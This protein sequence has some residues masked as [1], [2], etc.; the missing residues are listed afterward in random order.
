[1]E[2]AAMKKIVP[3]ITLALGLWLL[4]LLLTVLHAQK[5][6]ADLLN[7]ESEASQTRQ[8]PQSKFKVGHRRVGHTIRRVTVPGS[9]QGELRVVEVH[10]WYPA[11]NERF[12]RAPKT[13]Y[14]SALYGRPLEWDPLIPAKWDPLSWSVEAEIA[15][16]DAPIDSN[17]QS[18]PVLVFSHGNTN[19]PFDYA[20]TLEQIAGEGFVVAAPSHT[21]NTQDDV[22]VDF[23]NEE[24]RLAGAAK[25]LFLCND[26]LPG[27]CFRNVVLCND[28]LPGPCFKERLP[29]VS[30]IT[31][32]MRDRV[33]DVTAVLDSL[34]G[35]HGWLG[36]RADVNR[37]G[38][39]G[40]SRGSVTA[41]AAAGGSTIWECGLSLCPPT[42][43][44]GPEPRVK[45]VMGLAI[46]VP[47]TTLA[48]NLANIT[49]PSLLVAGTLDAVSPQEVSEAAFEQ[50]SSEE[51][52]F[53]AIQGAHHRSYSSANCNL[54]QSAGAIAQASAPQ[55]STR[56]VLDWH[57]MSH[58]S[59]GGRT[60]NA[61]S[62]KDYC[63]YDTFVNPVDIRQITL[64]LSRFDVTA[65]NVP[66]TGLDTDEVK[67]GVKE[68]AVAFFGTVLKRVGNDGI[69]F[70][71]YLAPKWLEKHVAMVG[72]AEAFASADALCPPGQ[73]VN[74][75]F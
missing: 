55:A 71:R 73:D 2:S 28:G 4:S 21:G 33:R 39:F 25:P 56:A 19:D 59:T 43:G 20:Y 48:V 29:S 72:R 14:S 61:G 1:M 51:K 24:A 7:A 32:S 22:R 52:L 74:C 10:L 54:T 41:L 6:P 50:I 60:G 31:R 15:R 34:Q 12:S 47:T 42:W 40:H 17:G 11:D 9:A 27:P 26:G 23:I 66:E 64:T 45:A 57:M 44:F 58:L 69:H 13:R 37:A 8:H 49:V 63:R 36:D 67:E 18:F 3:S 65:D 38:V 16:E 53:V 62:S 68:M 5:S 70:S 35:P 75:E 30:A 46:G